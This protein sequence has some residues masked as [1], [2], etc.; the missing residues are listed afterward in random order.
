MISYSTDHAQVQLLKSPRKSKTRKTT[1]K[2]ELSD[3]NGS[4]DESEKSPKFLDVILEE[5][6]EEGENETKIL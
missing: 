3:E 5:I 4:S 6:G 2:R 1:K